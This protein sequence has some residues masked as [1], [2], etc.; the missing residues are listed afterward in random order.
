[1]PKT[2]VPETSKPVFIIELFLPSG[3]YIF[4]TRDVELVSLGFGFGEEG[5]GEGGFGGI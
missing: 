5:F 4:A 3:Y 1:M 2:D